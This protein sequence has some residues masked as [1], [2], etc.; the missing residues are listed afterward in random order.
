MPVPTEL[1][2]THLNAA[3]GPL[4]VRLG[5]DGPDLADEETFH[6]PATLHAA[7]CQLRGITWPLQFYPGLLLTATWTVGG[8]ILD[9]TSERLPNPV[10]YAGITLTHATDLTILAAHLSQAAPDT[11]SAQAAAGNH[12]RP[13]P[14]DTALDGDRPDAPGSGNADEPAEDFCGSGGPVTDL[15]YGERGLADPGNRSYLA[16]L[17]RVVARTI[18]PGQDGVRGFTAPVLVATAFA[19]LL[20][21]RDAVGRAHRVLDAYAARGRLLRLPGKTRFGLAPVESREEPP[22]YLWWP[23]GSRPPVH[24]RQPMFGPAV[25]RPHRVPVS[26][27]QLPD[28]WEPSPEK[29][30]SWPQVHASLG[31]TYLPEQLPPGHTWV[32]AHERGNDPGWRSGA[33][34]RR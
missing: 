7:P 2:D 5:H 11:T 29:I 10:N 13:A 9:V 14:Q 16:L 4:A 23:P 33:V 15:E 18:E 28:G 22:T 21:P 6:E 19:G 26:L 17:L 32:E 25:R 12:A 24:R 1:H 31:P 34:L 27:R 20:I 3:V 8:R 30:A